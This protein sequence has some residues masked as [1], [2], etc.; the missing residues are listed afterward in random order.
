MFQ[1]GQRVTIIGKSAYNFSD[2]DLEKIGTI[3]TIVNIK[4]RYINTPYYYCLYKILFDNHI[5][6]G[7]I[8]NVYDSNDLYE[9]A[10][11]SD[12]L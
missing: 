7:S 5:T 3:G 4:V 9:A 11:L 1:L 2:K 6:S 8:F 10:S 12:T